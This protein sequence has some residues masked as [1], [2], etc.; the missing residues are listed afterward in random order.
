MVKEAAVAVRAIPVKITWKR[1][2]L[3]NLYRKVPKRRFL[4]SQRNLLQKLNLLLKSKISLI[5]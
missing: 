4:I 2:R 5:K 3:R 1:R